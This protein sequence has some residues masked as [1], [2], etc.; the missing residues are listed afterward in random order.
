VRNAPGGRLSLTWNQNLNGSTDVIVYCKFGVA[1]E[2]QHNVPVQALSYV[3]GSRQEAL[4][5]RSSL[6]N[7]LLIVKKCGI[8]DETFKI[9]HLETQSLCSTC[10]YNNFI[11]SGFDVEGILWSITWCIMIGGTRSCEDQ[12][13]VIL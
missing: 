3:S 4:L 13:C 6:A 8:S 7:E 1:A 5:C 2:I 11:V 9:I 12:S 10:E